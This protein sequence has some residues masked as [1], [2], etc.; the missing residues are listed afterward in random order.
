MRAFLLFPLVI[1]AACA[2][3]SPKDL[4]K[5]STL[6]ACYLAMME[7]DKKPM[8]EAELQRR[9][10]NCEQYSAELKKMADQ[11]IRAGGGPSGMDAAKSAGAPTS[12][13]GGMGGGGMGR[14]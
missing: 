8:V 13:G 6:D 4:E 3:T 12:S 2:S 5:M 11:E 9:N 10:A 14:Y 7:P 1:I